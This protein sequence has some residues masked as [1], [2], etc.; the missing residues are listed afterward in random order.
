MPSLYYWLIF[1]PE[2]PI[3]D[4]LADGLIDVMESAWG[5]EYGSWDKVFGSP[6]KKGTHL[7]NKRDVSSERMAVYNKVQEALGNGV[8]ID[9]GLFK[10]IGKELGIG[11]K[12]KT[13]NHYYHVK[14]RLEKS[15]LKKAI[16]IASFMPES[17]R[18]QVLTYIINIYTTMA[19]E[20][21][22]PPKN[23]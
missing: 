17:L 16:Y 8:P 12:T 15:G 4:W 20:T 9:C 11:G 3:P 14:N 2:E 5:G 1:N 19:A 22:G 7:E 6:H 21:P 23:F 13:E 10:S 18:I